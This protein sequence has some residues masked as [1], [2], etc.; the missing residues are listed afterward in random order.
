MSVSEAGADEALHVIAPVVDVDQH[1]ADHASVERESVCISTV[2]FRNK[3]L[4]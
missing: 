1:R 2:Q 4:P 3:H